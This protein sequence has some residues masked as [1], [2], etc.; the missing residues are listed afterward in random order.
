[1]TLILYWPSYLSVLVHISRDMEVEMMMVEWEAVDALILDLV[2]VQPLDQRGGG[3][4]AREEEAWVKKRERFD[5]MMAKE[6]DKVTRRKLMKALMEVE[7]EMDSIMEQMFVNKLKGK[8]SDCAAQELSH[9]QSKMQ[10]ETK[11][12]SE[13]QVIGKKGAKAISCTAVLKEIEASTRKK[14]LGMM[15]ELQRRN[16]FRNRGA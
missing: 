9:H 14:K 8:E 1:M 4:R 13:T 6:R 3:K 10:V 11:K 2:S 12:D 16:S 7:E 5:R 15:K